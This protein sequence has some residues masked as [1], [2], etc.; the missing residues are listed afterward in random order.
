MRS[1]RTRRWARYQ[2]EQLLPLLRGMGDLTSVSAWEGC[3]GER[4]MRVGI[5]RFI[6]LPELRIVVCGG[7][8]T[9]LAEAMHMR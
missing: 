7:E 6:R 3:D 5:A 4:A 1:G 9:E 8:R 2:D